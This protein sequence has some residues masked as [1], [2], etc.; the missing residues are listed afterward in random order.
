MLCDSSFADNDPFKCEGAIPS[1]NLKMWCNINFSKVRS[2]MSKR[3]NHWIMGDDFWCCAVLRTY[4]QPCST[5]LWAAHKVCYAYTFWRGTEGYPMA[6]SN[7]LRNIIYG[8]PFTTV[9]VTPSNSRAP[10]RH[11]I[12]DALHAFGACFSVFSILD[13]TKSIISKHHTDFGIQSH[14]SWNVKET[15]IYDRMDAP[16]LK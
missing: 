6:A 7:D 8:R 15:L 14:R 3:L 2:S 4:E 16:R 11:I 9:I 10:L 13:S 12:C 1:Y 5:N